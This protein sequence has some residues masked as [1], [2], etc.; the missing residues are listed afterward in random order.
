MLDRHA[1]DL[2]AAADELGDF[3]DHLRQVGI[4]GF[5]AEKAFDPEYFLPPPKRARRSKDS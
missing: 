5:V 2:D 1:D 4:R 3:F